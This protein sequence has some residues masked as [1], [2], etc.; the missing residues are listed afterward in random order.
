MPEIGRGEE[1]TRYENIH[2]PLVS[3]VDLKIL[4][5]VGNKHKVGTVFVGQG[6]D[7]RDNFLLSVRNRVLS[8]FLSGYISFIG[9]KIRLLQFMEHQVGVIVQHKEVRQEGDAVTVV[10]GLQ[11]LVVGE[12]KETAT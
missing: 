2:V 5:R 3:G 9:I 1:E 8:N 12:P 11:T 10:S 7:L 4:R 6:V